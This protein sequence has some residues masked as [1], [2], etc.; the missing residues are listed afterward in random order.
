MGWSAGPC[1]I[2]V[3]AAQTAWTSP[4]WSAAA[5]AVAGSARVSAAMSTMSFMAAQRRRTTRVALRADTAQRRQHLL[6]VGPDRAHRVGLADELQADDRP[7]LDLLDLADA[8][9]VLLGIRGDD[10]ALLGELLVAH[11]LV[12]AALHVGRVG[13]LVAVDLAQLRRLPARRALDRLLLVLGPREGRLEDDLAGLAAVLRARRAVGLDDLAGDLGVAHRPQ[14]VAVL[15]RDPRGLRPEGRDIEL[16]ARPGPRVELGLLELKPAAVHGHRLAVP[17]PGDR[18]EPLVEALELLGGW[19]PVEPERHLVDRLARAGAQP[20][21][22]GVHRLER[23]PGLGDRARVVV[24][25]DR[26]DAAADW[27]GRALPDGAEVDPR[28]RAAAVGEPR[29]PVVGGAQRV[30]A[31]LLGG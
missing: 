18:L 24:V 9:D 2:Q 7:A 30:E 6:A 12:G 20:H 26:R 13:D 21:A 4:R 15:A 10:E 17:Q 14:P 23:H 29:R 31:G 25:H 27:L 11:L 28:L 3:D 5:R 16:G 1:S 19:R 22:P 8:L